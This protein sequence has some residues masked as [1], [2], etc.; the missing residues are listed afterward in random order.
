M[1]ELKKFELEPV[2]LQISS[3]KQ[4]EENGPFV[5]F[6]GLMLENLPLKDKRK[7]Q[8]I[9]KIAADEFNALKIDVKDTKEKLK[10]KE[11]KEIQEELFIL[12]NEVVKID[13]EKVSLAAI[14]AITSSTVYNF[15]FIEKIAE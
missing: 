10:D 11:E 13:V 8:K 15:D 1:I 3:Y 5:L 6:S 7:L 14:E 9:H 2:L 12:L 4:L